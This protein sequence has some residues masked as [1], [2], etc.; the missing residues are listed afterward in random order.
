MPRKPRLHVAGGLYH[1][2]LR[3]NNRQ[4]IFFSDA[5]RHR[6][7]GLLATGLKRYR[8]RIHAYC[9]MT[10]HV[11]MAV[12]VSDRPL[13][14]LMRWLGTQYARTTNKRMQRTG[15][16]FERRHRAILVDADAYLLQLVRYIHCNP[17]RAGMVTDP[18]QYQ[19]SSHRAYLCRTKTDWLTIDWVLSM[20]AA[21]RK[22]GRQLYAAFMSETDDQDHAVLRIG[23]GADDVR[24]TNDDAVVDQTPD[25]PPKRVPTRSLDELIQDLCRPHDLTEADLVSNRRLRQ[26]ARIRA[27]IVDRAL[28][29]G[30][31]TLAELSRRFN[32]AESTLYR[33]WERYVQTNRSD[34]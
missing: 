18:V 9:W 11:H 24:R 32:R 16:L 33:S 2:I 31:A 19:W 10:N 20:F 6:W 1:V 28:A 27:Q 30:I 14:H 22:S 3:G 29:S 34:R 5:D 15:H 23:G 25:S 13:P 8:C 26:H 21:N 12:Q 4:K 17:V 7:M